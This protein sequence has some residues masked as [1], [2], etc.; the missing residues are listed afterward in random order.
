MLILMIVSNS[1][2]G[3]GFDILESTSKIDEMGLDQIR[4][5]RFFTR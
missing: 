3:I 4:I 2:K 5:N 1:T